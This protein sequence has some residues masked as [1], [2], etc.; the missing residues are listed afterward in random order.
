VDE[1]VGEE[2]YL[3]AYVMKRALMET[4][5]VEWDEGTPLHLTGFVMTFNYCLK[6]EQYCSSRIDH[7]L[8]PY[9]CH[10][11]RKVQRVE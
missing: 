2:V 1:I 8:M 9:H 7:Q 3:T 6:R 4:E 5:R 10:S 11:Q